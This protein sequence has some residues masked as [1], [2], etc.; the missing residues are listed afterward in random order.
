MLIG[1]EVKIKLPVIIFF[2]LHEGMFEKFVDVI[3]D[4]QRVSKNAHDLNNRATDLMVMFNDA[5]EAICDDGNMDL[6]T[7]GIFAFAPEGLNLE[8][9]LNPFEEQLDLPS[10]FVKERNFTCF[11]IE[12]VRIV[13]KRSLQI[14]SIID[15]ASD[16]NRIVA[17]VPASSESDSLVTKDIILSLKQILAILNLIVGMELL[18]DNEEGTSLFNAKESRQVKVST[19]KDIAGKSLIFNPVHRV[20]IMDL[21]CCDSVEDRYLSSNVNLCVNPDTSLRSPKF[22]P[23]EDRETEVNGC[24]VDSIESSVKFKIPGDSSL[25]GL[26]DHVEGKLFID[27]V[28]TEGV[29]L[30]DNTS[31][32]SSCSETEIIR[33]FCMS[34][35]YVSKFPKTGTARKLRKYKHTKMVPMSKTPVLCPVVVSADNTIELTFEPVGYL[36]EDIVPQMHICSNL[37]LG[38]KV[39]ISKVGHCFQELLCC[40]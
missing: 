19:V 27:F 33:T 11:E 17:F 14:W 9:L 13:C 24:R 32:R 37:K 5:N 28:I 10:V 29:G 36:V 23:S 25:L 22:C 4:K 30:G 3:L 20:D 26:T 34:L 6:D 39:R 16:G 8:M 15:N 7:D 12:V 2:I 31:V 21:C 38:T 35:D 40:A 18:P 1:L